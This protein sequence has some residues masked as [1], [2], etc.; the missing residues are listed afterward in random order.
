MWS[1]ALLL[2]ACSGSPEQREV[3]EP[4]PLDRD[5][6][7]LMASI[8]DGTAPEWLV[9]AADRVVA[10]FTDRNTQLLPSSTPPRGRSHDRPNRAFP[11]PGVL[12]N[13]RSHPRP[14]HG[15]GE[16]GAL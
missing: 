8:A 10:Q 16:S 9:Q 3:W 13:G 4:L 1:L 6:D 11:D 12:G 2:L 5:Q 14:R 7:A 15:R